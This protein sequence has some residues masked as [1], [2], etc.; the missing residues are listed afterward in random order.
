MVDEDAVAA[1]LRLVR[2][3]PA[4]TPVTAVSCLKG[5]FFNHREPRPHSAER[6]DKQL[7]RVGRRVSGWLAKER[8]RQ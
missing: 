7:V 2:E 8:R 1:S 4:S 3:R 5:A 6:N